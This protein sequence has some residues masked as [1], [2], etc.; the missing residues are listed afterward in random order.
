MKKMLN[1][2]F[3]YP[4]INNTIYLGQRG[5]PP[6]QGM[7]GPIAGKCEELTPDM[8]PMERIVL[9]EHTYPCV[10]DLLSRDLNYEYGYIAAVR[11]FFEEIFQSGA[12]MSKV[13]NLIYLGGVNDEYKGRLQNAQLYMAMIDKTDF[14]PAPREITDFKPLTEICRDEIFP[15]GKIGLVG[16]MHMVLVGPGF[17][18]KIKLYENLNLEM[19]MPSFHKKDLMRIIDEHPTSLILPTSL[20]QY[21]SDTE[22]F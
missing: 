3:L 21:E 11:E 12:D 1:V 14:N 4:I 6:H 7:Y 9:G 15:I 10:A 8:K 19:Q 5:T 22:T 18:P 17:F 13:R 20:F 2:G 16:I